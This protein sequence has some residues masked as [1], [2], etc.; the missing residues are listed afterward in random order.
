MPSCDK[1]YDVRPL[2]KILENRL[3]AN[4]VK[5][6]A[7]FNGRWPSAADGNYRP[8]SLSA[9]GVGGYFAGAKLPSDCLVAVEMIAS[10]GLIDTMKAGEFDKLYNSNFLPMRKDGLVSEANMGDLLYIANDAGYLAK[11]PHGGYMGENVIKMGTDSYWGFPAGVTMSFGDWEKALIGEYNKGLSEG[12][13][14]SKIPGFKEPA[15]LW[16]PYKLSMDLFDLRA[17]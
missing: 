4:V 5:E 10:E 3:R 15:Y 6:T 16:N 13:Q 17:P 2:I 1:H 11:H 9:A 14:I 7:R 12:E 8:D